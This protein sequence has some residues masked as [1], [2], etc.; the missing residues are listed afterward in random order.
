MIRFTVPG[1][2]V[3]W[4][5]AAKGGGHSFTHPY[6]RTYQREVRQTAEDA[7][8]GLEQRLALAQAA[9]DETHALQNLMAQTHPLASRIAWT[10][11]RGR[12]GGDGGGRARVVLQGR[13]RFFFF[14]F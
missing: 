13:T 1:P 3:A 5:R 4:Q 12:E 7:G 8:A 9:S 6:T 11:A 10:K 14:F 2:A